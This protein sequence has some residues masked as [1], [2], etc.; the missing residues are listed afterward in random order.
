MSDKFIQ[1]FKVSGEVCDNLIKYFNKHKELHVP[2]KVNNEELK[3]KS[4]ISTDMPF[5]YSN[6]SCVELKKYVE[7]M[8]VCFNEYKQLIPEIDIYCERFKLDANINIQKYEKKEAFFDWHYENSAPYRERIFVHMTYLNDVKEGGETAWYFQN[9]KIKPEKG[10]T[11][12]WPADWMYLH[13][14]YPPIKNKKYIIT[15]W[16]SKI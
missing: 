5:L 11:M 14:G 4:K 16:F 15:G 3:K 6:E 8:L 12:F 2:G 9:L 1:T 7:E 13:R 10:L